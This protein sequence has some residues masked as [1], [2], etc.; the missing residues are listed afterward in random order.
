MRCENIDRLDCILSGLPFFNFPQEVRDQLVD[1]VYRAL[2]PGGVFIAFQY[3]RQMKR[4]LGELF[5]I[6]QIAF[7]PLNLPPA[8]VYVCRKR[9]RND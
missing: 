3:S 7:V 6:E 4:Q 2:R 5:E 1:Q 8:F 9:E